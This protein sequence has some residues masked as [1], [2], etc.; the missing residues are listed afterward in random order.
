MEELNPT[1]S[2][3]EFVLF[4][5]MSYIVGYYVDS[6]LYWQ[7]KEI[8]MIVSLSVTNFRSIKEEQV[9]NLSVE[10]LKDIHVENLAFSKDNKTA[11]VKTA[12]IYGANASG[13]SNILV[14]FRALQYMVSKSS[15]WQLDEEIMCYEPFR[16]DS[17]T[18]NSA[19][20]FEIEFIGNDQLQY[21]YRVDFSKHQINS[22]SLYFYPGV[23]RAKLYT[24]QTTSSG[25]Y[26]FSAGNA[27]KGKKRLFPCMKNVLYLSK[28]ANEAD[29]P[30]VIKDVYRFIRDGFSVIDQRTGFHSSVLN[31]DSYR[32]KLCLLLS[33]ADTGI[34][35]VRRKERPE[36]E[37]PKFEGIGSLPESVKDEINKDFKW[38]PVFIHHNIEEDFELQDESHGTKRLYELAPVII[39][40]LEDGGTLI[41]DEIEDGMHSYISEFIVKMFNDPQLN[42]NNAQLIFSS[43]DTSLMD[44]D[45][46]RRDQIWFTEKSD[47]GES[48]LYC[49]DEF[50][51]V[52]KDTPFAK[53]YHQNRFDAIP[54]LD[55]NKFR[56]QFLAMRKAKSDV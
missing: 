24:R 7:L 22:E 11:C 17:D 36:S 18:K 5:I 9:L 15:T 40:F 29:A 47:K 28:A 55:Y 45:Y 30:E 10:N 6:R 25:E 44:E 14:A 13:K 46:M 20:A 53:W 49:L 37:Y 52:R 32:E 51:E 8:K 2:L 35:S 23:K 3:K 26:E 4:R 33:C 41:I 27:L 31:D 34:S 12:G 56:E 54:R 48:V 1:V 16:L 21:I 19:C 43:H 42:V 50:K 38:K 39:S